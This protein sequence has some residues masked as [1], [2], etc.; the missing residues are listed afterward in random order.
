MEGNFLT[1]KGNE[2]SCQRQEDPYD[3]RFLHLHPQ[4]EL[5]FSP[6][7]VK[8]RVVLNGE[9][10][11]LDK[12]CA[13]LVPPF[14]LHSMSSV[15]ADRFLRICLFFSQKIIENVPDPYLPARLNTPECLCFELTEEQAKL[16]LPLAELPTQEQYDMTPEEKELSFVLLLNMLFRFCPEERIKTYGNLRFYVQ[17]V[18][19][20]VSENYMYDISS[21]SVAREFSISRSKLDRDLRAFANCTL[22]DF[23]DLCRLNRARDLLQAKHRYAIDEVGQMCGFRNASYFYIFFRKHMGMSPLEYRKQFFVSEENANQSKQNED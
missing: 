15:D 21:E 14:F 5:Y 12:P 16:L 7:A 18:L 19:R 23:L 6:E 9:E 1:D 4:Y 2:P 10:Y 3:M 17:N 13:I 20:Y 11:V 8:Q 22:H